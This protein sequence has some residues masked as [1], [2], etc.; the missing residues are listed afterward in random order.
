VSNQVSLT[1]EPRSEHGKG[2]A[3][4]LRRT[5]RVPAIVY[6]FE[7]EPNAIHVDALELY[8]ALHTEA[9]RNVLIRLEVSGD[10]TLVIARDLQTHPIRGEVLHVD[11]YA[12]DRDAQISVEVPVH[13]VGE[14]DV[15]A[16][17]GILN[18][19]L[20]TVPIAVKPLD[21][22]NA[23]DID[24]AGMAIGDVRRVEDLTAQLPEGAEWEVE[25]DRT[26]VTINAPITEEELEELEAEAG[27]EMEEPEEVVAAEGE[28][29][30]APAEPGAETEAAAED[31]G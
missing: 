22:P 3:G 4:R 28:E 27:I 13:I 14:D 26:V 25:L 31:E 20:Y 7:T 24:V 23:L 9:G 29:A 15:V 18:Q 8:H 19:I 16:D 2:P 17:G 30:E 12:V 1:A 21:V 11:F 6:G 10:T 5:G